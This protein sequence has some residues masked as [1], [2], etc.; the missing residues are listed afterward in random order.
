[1]IRG[2]L[3]ICGISNEFLIITKCFY[4]QNLDRPPA[5]ALKKGRKNT[6]D[7]YEKRSWLVKVNEKLLFEKNIFSV[8]KRE[9][10]LFF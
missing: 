6:W 8:K 1:M 4:F 2:G 9:S 3:V 10:R 5:S 7:Q